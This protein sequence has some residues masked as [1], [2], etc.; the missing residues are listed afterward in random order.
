MIVGVPT[1]VKPDE[2]RVGMRL[3]GVEMLARQGHAVLIQS[4]AGIGAGFS[5]DAYRG[6]GG[7][8]VATAEEVWGGADLVVKVKE[9]QA[10]EI[11]LIRDG[12]SIFTYFHFA[13]DRNLTLGCLDSGCIAIAYETLTDDHGQLPLLTPMSEIAGALAI[14]EGADY[15]ENPHGGR[16]VLLGGVPGV[17]PGHVLVLGGGV[18][19]SW[20]A[21]I[22]AGMGAHVVIL[23]INLDRLR[24]LKESMPEN[25]DTVYSDPHAIREHLSWADLIVGAVLIPGAKAPH[26]ISRADLKRMKRGSVIVDV[27]IDQ[28]GCV[29]TAKMTTHSD[30]VYEVDG[31]LHYCVGNMPGAVARTSTLALTNATLPWVLK[32]ADHGP[33]AVSQLDPHFANAVNMNR[34]TLT[35][36]PVAEAHGLTFEPLPA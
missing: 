15:L 30:P 4:G 17:E 12:Q 6:A 5:D 32:L 10:Q 25:V 9:P 29:E 26:L 11:P 1:E 7:Q 28:G 2:Y 27:A 23:D 21:R 31:V 35:S 36:R 13:S 14:Q 18:V 20:S 22:A 19:G 8:I 3:V 33:D 34:G 16:G 24:E